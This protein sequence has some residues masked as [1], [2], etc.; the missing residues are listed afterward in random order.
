MR[1]QERNL[2][3][4][5]KAEQFLRIYTHI[6][7][8]KNDC[9]LINTT[10]ILN[11]IVSDLAMN[12]CYYADQYNWMEFGRG[13][14]AEMTFYAKQSQNLRLINQSLDYI[15][16]QLECLV[17]SESIDAIAITPRSITRHNQLLKILKYRL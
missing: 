2:D 16:L 17:R 8:L 7:S 10:Q 4:Q 13:K 11:T 1:F 5:Q 12:A 9:G 3:P 14:L 15:Q 6:Q